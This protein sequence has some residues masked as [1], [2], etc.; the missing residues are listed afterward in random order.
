MELKGIIQSALSKCKVDHDDL[1]FMSQAIEERILA[2]YILTPKE[3][4]DLSEKLDR[5]Q[6]A[7]LKG[8]APKQELAAAI[9][10]ADE[11]RYFEHLTFENAEAWERLRRKAH[12]LQE[13]LHKLKH[14]R[15]T[16]RL[17][18]ELQKMISPEA[19]EVYLKIEEE[20]NWEIWRLQQEGATR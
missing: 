15:A 4:L 2:N 12:Y 11:S 1:E 19:W 18:D 20:T 6:E 14:R 8:E 13:L 16:R 3:N 9:N 10:E 7:I 5:L 17:Q